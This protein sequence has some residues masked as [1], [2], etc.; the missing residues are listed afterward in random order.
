MPPPPVPPPL[1]ERQQGQGRPPNEP[2]DHSSCERPLT[3][4]RPSGCVKQSRRWT[5]AS[6]EPRGSGQRS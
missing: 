2:G 5:R 4:E 3:C 6:K 1:L